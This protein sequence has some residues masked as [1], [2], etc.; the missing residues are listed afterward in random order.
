MSDK[1]KARFDGADKCTARFHEFDGWAGVYPRCWETAG[2]TGPHKTI[3][4]LKFT[5][6]EALGDT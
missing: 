6:N 4:G 1:R 5:D 2:H 3:Y